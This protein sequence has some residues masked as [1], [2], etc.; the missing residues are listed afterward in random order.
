[1]LNSEKDRL[2]YGEQLR[3]PAGYELEAAIATTYTLDLNTLLAIPIALCFSDSL[4]GDLKGEKFALYDAV[5]QLSGKIKVF[6]QQGCLSVPQEY[7]RLFTLLEPML[8]PVVPQEFASFHPKLWL[9]RYKHKTN[10]QDICYRSIILSRNLTFDR[11]WDIA[12]SFDGV[13]QSGHNN[14]NDSWNEFIRELLSLSPEFKYAQQLKEDLASIKWDNISK[15]Y[16][17]QL[18]A[19]G[20][21][22]TR[23]KNRGV[24]LDLR[25]SQYDKIMVV[26]PFLH[27]AALQWLAQYVPPKKRFLFS[28]AEELNALGAE[29]L[30][31]WQCYAINALLVDSEERFDQIEE[32]QT[33]PQP[34]NLHA[35]MIITEKRKTAYWH[36]GSA[37]AS[38]AALGKGPR[39]KE[40]RNNETMVSMKARHSSAKISALFE[41]WTKQNL[42]IPHVFSEKTSEAENQQSPQLRL[43]VHEIIEKQWYISASQERLNEGYTVR[44]SVD[45]EPTLPHSISAHVEHLAISGKRELSSMIWEDVKGAKI[46]SFFKVTLREDKAEIAHEKALFLKGHLA[47]EGGDHRAEKLMQSMFNSKEKAISYLQMLLEVKPDK[48]FLSAIERQSQLDLEVLGSY[49]LS[50]TPLFEQLLLAASRHQQVLKRVAKTVHKMREAD[51]ELPEEFL[52]LWTHFEERMRVYK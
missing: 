31:D 28:R 4:D 33:T 14:E 29:A 51:V 50:N 36:L 19:G 24:P 22:L 15:F 1:M 30:Q 11:S 16:D 45:R 32:R 26:S 44:I 47:I 37:N 49:L 34:Q 2:D 18:L 13:V 17:T 3:P 39:S 42:F 25:Y 21:S 43:A 10:P 9:L 6:F 48:N 46:S 12:L 27:P 7:N 40:V 23:I 5:N 41:Q 38:L 8:L 52:C 35:K 20:P